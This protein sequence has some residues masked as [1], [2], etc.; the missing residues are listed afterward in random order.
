VQLYPNPSYTIGVPLRLRST[1]DAISSSAGDSVTFK[2][3]ASKPFAGRQYLLLMSASG[4][5][6]GFDLDSLHV[7]LNL[8]NVL[9]ASWVF[10]NTLVLQNTEGF[11][12]NDTIRA[13][14]TFDPLPNDLTL[15]VGSTLSFAY[16]TE[17]PKDF[18]SEVVQVKVT[19]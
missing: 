10:R 16:L 8:D 7:P 1:T 9:L 15:L 5:E 11:L 14:A 13:E 17:N 12:D 2:L 3:H 18:A 6:P 4:T 19:P